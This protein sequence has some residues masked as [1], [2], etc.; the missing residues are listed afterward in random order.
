MDSSKNCVGYEKK[1]AIIINSYDPNY[2]PKGR[3][4]KC[5]MMR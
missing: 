5:Q 4:L 1:Y 3:E 2:K